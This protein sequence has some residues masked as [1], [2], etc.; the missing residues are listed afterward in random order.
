MQ[1][2]VS[3]SDG[4]TSTVAV[5]A[6][7]T[8]AGLRKRIWAQRV[9]ATATASSAPCSSP[10]CSSAHRLIFAGKQLDDHRTLRDYNINEGS[11]IHQLVR[12]P[13]GARKVAYF[14][15]GKRCIRSVHDARISFCCIFPFMNACPILRTSPHRHKLWPPHFLLFPFPS[16]YFHCSFSPLP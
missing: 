11:T 13:G 16:S 9:R 8:V 5:G 6:N 12:L 10:A 2:F 3:R 1:L 14:Y 7:E 4:G 15:D